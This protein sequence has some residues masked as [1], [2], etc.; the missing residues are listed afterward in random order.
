MDR[1]FSTLLIL[2]A[3]TSKEVSF[4]T[5]AELKK[6]IADLLSVGD[7]N[8]FYYS[9]RDKLINAAIN[10]NMQAEFVNLSMEPYLRVCQIIRD[11]MPQ[12]SSIDNFIDTHSDNK[13]IELCGKLA[14]VRAIL[15][16]ESRSEIYTDQNRKLDFS[17]I[18]NTWYNK[19]FQLL[20]QDASLEQL[21]GRLN[22]LNVITFNYDR[23][24]EHFLYYSLINYYQIDNTSAAELI[25]NIGIYHPYGTVGKLPWM[26]GGGSIEFG[27]EP[28]ELQLLELVKQ[29]RT[30]TEGTEPE[31]SEINIIRKAVYESDCIIFLGFGFHP[32]NMALLDSDNYEPIDK[33]RDSSVCFATAKGISQ[34]DCDLVISD[35]QKLTG[36]EKHQIHLRNDLTCTDLFSKYRRSLSKF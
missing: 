8:G 11:A 31:S 15:E 25:S 27:A 17:R 20:V 10:R 19:F 5:G 28:N 30:F 23:S 18:E 7:E 16:A 4:P 29:I 2:G 14:I 1:R 34:H 9:I 12:A 36:F 22:N 26:R 35:I 24:F 21:T 32:Q 3:G 33:E 6:N 13:K